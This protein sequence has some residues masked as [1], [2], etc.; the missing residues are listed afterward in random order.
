MCCKDSWN[1]T[2][3]LEERHDRIKTTTSE[4]H[5]LLFMKCHVPDLRSHVSV[6]PVNG[7]LGPSVCRYAEQLE[8]AGGRSHFS[9]VPETMGC[10]FLDHCCILTTAL[11]LVRGASP[12]IDTGSCD[13][14]EQDIHPIRAP[15]TEVT[16]FQSHFL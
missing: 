7:V 13:K 14:Q 3:F 8:P 6:L 16:H 15:R 5:K 1:G 11:P 9:D 4:A 12:F 10:F 2:D